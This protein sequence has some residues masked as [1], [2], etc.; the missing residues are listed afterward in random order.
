MKIA[1]KQSASS[2]TCAS[3]HVSTHESFVSLLEIH[4]KTY[5][6]CKKERLI[7]SEMDKDVLRRLLLV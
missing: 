6:K 2:F 4:P 3:F 1:A 7:H 5:L